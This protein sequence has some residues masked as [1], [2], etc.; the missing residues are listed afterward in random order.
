MHSACP[1]SDAP[2]DARV[3][4]GVTVFTDRLKTRL[5]AQEEQDREK[6]QRH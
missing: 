2:H 3:C 4:Q 5:L 6:V 1:R